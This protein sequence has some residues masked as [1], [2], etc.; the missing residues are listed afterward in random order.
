M[1]LIAGLGNPGPD[2]KDTRHNIGFQVINLLCQEL[3][4]RLSN[5]RFQSENIRTKL[6]GKEIILLRPKTFMNLSGKT[7]KGCSDFYRLKPEDILII[8][9][10]LDLAVGRIK[11]VGQGGSG[12]HRGVKSVI[13]HLG[14]R[15]FPRVKIGIGRPLRGE[16]TEDYVLSP[17]Y[18][19]QKDTIKRVTRLA[20]QACRLFV[21]DGVETAMNHINC[22]QL[23][24][25]EEKNLCK[26]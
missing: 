3:R 15:H 21:S 17:F 22:Q 13:D 23:E 6:H 10:D 14:S 25:K 4:V 1:D 19:N 2:Y 9:D 12:G 5:R 8:H 24:H 26:D 11:V 18:D 16:T 20:V 7:I